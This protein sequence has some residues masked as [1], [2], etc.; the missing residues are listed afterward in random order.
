MAKNMPNILT[1]VTGLP[2]TSNDIAIT[3]M[4]L[5]ADATA[6]VNGVTSDNTLKA[7]MFCSQLSTPSVKSSAM[8]L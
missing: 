6:Y 7:I 3:K 4:R 5:D 2:N 8:T 1:H